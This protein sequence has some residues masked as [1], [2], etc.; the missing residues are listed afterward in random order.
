MDLFATVAVLLGLA[1]LFSYI[2]EEFLHLEKTI[3]LM[4]LALAMSALVWILSALGV[5]D[6][7]D[8]QRELVSKLDLGE[9][10][11]KGVLC[12]MLFAGSVN[13]KI[14]FLDQEKWTIGSLALGG[15]LIAWLLTGFLIW[16]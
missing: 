3:G 8:E 16:G 14:K 2:N 1:A 11:L 4:V 6:A 10:L 9:T 7:L 13:V 12:F 15:T 5:V